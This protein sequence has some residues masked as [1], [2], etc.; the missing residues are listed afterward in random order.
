MWPREAD[1]LAL[2]DH[3]TCAL[4]S[5]PQ[6][7][8]PLT[9]TYRAAHLGSDVVLLLLRDLPALDL[10]ARRVAVQ[11]ALAPTKRVAPKY[12]GKLV[13]QVEESAGYRESARASTTLR[14]FIFAPREGTSLST[15][16]LDARRGQ[17][18]PAA[19]ASALVA[20]LAQLTLSEGRTHFDP[21]TAGLDAGGLWA[22]E[23]TLDAWLRAVKHEA[24]EP[25]KWLG[26]LA[27]ESLRGAL[28]DE[29]SAVFGL[30]V[31]LHELIAGRALFDRPSAL[32]TLK[33]L[34]HDVPAP[35]AK[36]IPGTPLAVAACAQAMLDRDPKRRPTAASIARELLPHAAP[37]ASVLSTL[38]ADAPSDAPFLMRL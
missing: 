14:Y 23:P 15:L 7:R 3:T 27:P 35:L 28:L 16:V 36:L 31:L 6:L 18:W 9:A 37:F 26:Y 25:A 24:R 30:G 2:D 5:P 11:T 19:C 17:P 38:K 33:S 22:L 8:G 34:S 4:R 29:A 32:A 13:M 12:K 1:V 21:L 10:L 20:E